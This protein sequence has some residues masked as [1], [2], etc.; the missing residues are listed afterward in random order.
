MDKRRVNQLVKQVRLDV[1]KT[2]KIARRNV[3]SAAAFSKM[4][5]GQ[6]ILRFEELIQILQ[7]L[8]VSLEDFVVEYVQAEITDTVR[9]KFVEAYM[10]LPSDEAKQE[11]IHL[12]NELA[13]RYPD[14]QPDEMSVYFDIKQGLHKNFPDDISP[15]TQKE[16]NK[17]VSIM[18]NSSR[19]RFLN[20]DYRLISNLIMDMTEK[21]MMKIFGKVFPLD[22]TIQIG[23]K[24][25][26]NL[27]NILV[28]TLTPALKR[29]EYDL[30]RYVLNV[31][32]EHEY[33]YASNYYFKMHIA[34]LEN[35]Y[36][37]VTESDLDALGR[38]KTF[39]ETV[40][41][42]EPEDNVKKI[43]KEVKGILNDEGGDSFSMNDILFATRF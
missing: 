14:L 19:K 23:I 1:G 12:Y 2:Q 30:F 41:M 37:S 25:K 42:L 6:K 26:E 17:I 8:S 11:I 28:N 39:L 20:E 27:C 15:V 7:N 21:Q 29:Q 9:I 36:L 16:L 10:K 5:N 22:R 43:K 33:L 4:E 24:T 40:E 31:S 3:L 35:L 38:V 18:A 13:R 34:Y 32:K